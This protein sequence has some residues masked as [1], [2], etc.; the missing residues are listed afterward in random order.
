MKVYELKEI[1]ETLDP[2]LDVVCDSN[3]PR[4]KGFENHFMFTDV[5]ECEEV[6]GGGDKFVMLSLR[7][8]DINDN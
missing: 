6:E 4:P 5:V 3:E 8:F 2:M 7:R 1:L